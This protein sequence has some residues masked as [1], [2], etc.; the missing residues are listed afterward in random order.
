MIHNYI[1]KYIRTCV[2]RQYENIRL[3]EGNTKC[4][5][6]LI[7]KGTL[8]QVIICL[9][10]R[11]PYPP[12]NS[13]Y[14]YSVYLFT[15]G[16]GEGGVEPERRLEGQQFTKIGRK[17]QHDW[18]Y[19]H[20]INSDKHLPQSTLQANFLGDNILLWCLYLLSPFLAF[21]KQ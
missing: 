20:P 1:S 13:I 16:R 4:H 12:L 8:R 6:K 11:S 15:Q 18:L 3:I 2:Y 9:R 5:K 14:V 21:Y 10:P 17:Y 7:C 19:L